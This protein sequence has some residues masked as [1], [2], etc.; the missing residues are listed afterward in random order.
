MNS[1][2]AE[3]EEI[4]SV[5]EGEEV[6]PSFLRQSEAKENDTIGNNLKNLDT[7]SNSTSGATDIINEDDI[8]SNQATGLVGA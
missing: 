7:T 3:L 8:Y 1:F 6:L 5:L 2:Q 4:G